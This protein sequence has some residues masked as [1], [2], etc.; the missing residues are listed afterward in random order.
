VST[1][2]SR[3]ALYARTAGLVLAML[4][5]ACLLACAL[6]FRVVG[7][8]LRLC[9]EGVLDRCAAECSKLR[10]A[11]PAAGVGPRTATN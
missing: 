8:G 11:L 7:G 4:A 3:P 2:I 9:G 10:R 5:G 6:P 1:R